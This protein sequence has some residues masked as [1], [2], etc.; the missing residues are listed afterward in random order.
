MCDLLW[1]D[2]M[3]DSRND[4]EFVANSLRGCSYYFGSD[5]CKNFLDRNNLLTIIR[6]HEIIVIHIK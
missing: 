1:A 3:S 4:K 6:A 5:A 2:P